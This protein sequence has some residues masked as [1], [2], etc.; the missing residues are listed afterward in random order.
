MLSE[1]TMLKVDEARKLLL[2]Q[3]M[4]DRDRLGQIVALIE[5]FVFAPVTEGVVESYDPRLPDILLFFVF[6]IEEIYASLLDSNET[7]LS[8]SELAVYWTVADTLV[9]L[10]SALP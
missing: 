1:G 9:F 7:A 3:S 8:G 6:E 4:P 5:G 10:L 2:D